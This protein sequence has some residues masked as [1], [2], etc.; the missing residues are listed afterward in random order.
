MTDGSSSTS[1]FRV[2]AVLFGLLIAGTLLRLVLPSFVAWSDRSTW[3]LIAA[4]GAVLL[5][6]VGA[7]LVERFVGSA[8]NAVNGV[9]A[10]IGVRTGG[11]AA[12]AVIGTVVLDERRAGFLASLALL[13]L[14][15]LVIDSAVW[16]R[17]RRP[18]GISVAPRSHGGERSEPGG[19][20]RIS[21]ER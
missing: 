1:G 2:A 21:N 4:V 14:V 11:V 16:A 12:V 19:Q 17:S 7:V 20:E 5:S 18:S 3:E 15:A 8:S 10:A 9:L 6:F 13:Y